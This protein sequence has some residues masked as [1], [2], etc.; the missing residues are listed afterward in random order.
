MKLRPSSFSRS[1]HTEINISARCACDSCGLSSA[2]RM[3]PSC[4]TAA[5]NS[6]ISDQR[7]NSFC[8]LASSKA[9]LAY[10]RARVV[11]SDIARL[12]LR[13]QIVQHRAVRLGVDLFFKN[14]LRAGDSYHR[15]LLAQVVSGA[16]DFLLDVVLRRGLDAFT[17]VARIRLRFLDDLAGT[18]LRLIDDIGRFL[19]GFVKL[20]LCVLLGLLLLFLSTLGRSQT[21]SDFLLALFYGLDNRRPHISHGDPHE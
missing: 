14:L 9:A 13:R 11:S 21:V 7:S 1:S 5:I 15:Y 4:A 19:L 2:V 12:Q 17:F 8:S 20:L 6:S 18:S 16:I 10:G 3:S